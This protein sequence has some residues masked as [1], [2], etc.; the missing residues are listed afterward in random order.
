MT[1][2]KLILKAI[3]GQAERPPVWLMRQAGRHLPEYLALKEKMS[4]LELCKSP[5]DA[6][7]ASLQPIRRYD[8]D[9]VICFSDILVPLE[10]MGMHLSFNPGPV[11]RDPIRSY[12]DYSSLKRPDVKTQIP[13]I[14]EILSRLTKHGETQGKT[15]LGF[16]GAPFT[17][18]SYAI[19]GKTSRDFEAV[20]GW[21]RK[22]PRT[23][24]KLM[25]GLADLVLEYILCQ[26]EAGADLVQFFDTWA[27]WL[28][29]ED[30]R[31]YV[32][33][34]MKR[35]LDGAR[36][37]NLPTTL[38][39]NGCVHLIEEM[40]S[41]EPTVISVD[42][43]ESLLNYLKRIPNHIAVQGNLDPTCLHAHPDQVITMTQELMQQASNRPNWI[44]N[45][46]HGVLPNTPIAGVE[47]FVRT[48]QG[49]PAQS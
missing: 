2:E 48:I 34:S 36:K 47:A 26:Q 7:E 42:W 41:L 1:Q 20:K 28:S 19:E 5:E 17:L 45:L 23:F 4:F 14:L 37:A 22:E 10:A 38:Y 46:G 25:D 29:R 49:R 43:R 8:V 6:V 13:H 9:G 27:G 12:D 21:M 18:A 32:A 31:T 40:A 3:K 30:Y 11:F 33:P 35:L 44:A 24:L 16:T 39:I 15:I